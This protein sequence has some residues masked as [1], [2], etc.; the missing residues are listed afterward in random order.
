MVH[1]PQNYFS[2]SKTLLKEMPYLESRFAHFLISP[3]GINPK[4]SFSPIFNSSSLLSNFSR[5]AAYKPLPE[6]EFEERSSLFLWIVQENGLP[7]LCKSID[8]GFGS[9]VWKGFGKAIIVHGD[10]DELIPYYMAKQ[11]VDVIGAH[12]AQLFTAIGK[13]H[14]WDMS[15]FLGDPGLEKVEEAWEALDE[16]I[17]KAQGGH[18]S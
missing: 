4:P 14:G 10:Q 16:I 5:D 7:T 17:L 18:S 11:A 13:K 2:S 1:D 9:E 3:P 12:D 6:C 8:Q 15:L